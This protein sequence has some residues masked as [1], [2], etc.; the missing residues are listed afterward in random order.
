M[1]AASS[2]IPKHPEEKRE[3]LP[4]GWTA[5]RYPQASI[6]TQ[7]SHSISQHVVI[8]SSSGF[9]PDSFPGIIVR[10]EKSVIWRWKW[11]KQVTEWTFQWGERYSAVPKPCPVW[12]SGTLSLMILQASYTG[13]DG[14]NCI[15]FTTLHWRTQIFSDKATILVGRVMS[16]P[17]YEPGKCKCSSISKESA[18]VQWRS[19]LNP[20]DYLLKKKKKTDVSDYSNIILIQLTIQTRYV[21]LLN[22][23]ACGTYCCATKIKSK[24]TK[25]PKPT[26]PVELT[27]EAHLDHPQQQASLPAYCRTSPVLMRAKIFFYK[28]IRDVIRQQNTQNQCLQFTPWGTF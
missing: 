9:K 23:W 25:V 16:S 11:N 26:V 1:A 17:P 13:V 5:D 2:C 19:W 22:L 8:Q 27:R 18:V 7:F 10:Q 12:A 4:S 6:I 21:Q 15:V 14:S 28:T 3:N 20:R 24:R